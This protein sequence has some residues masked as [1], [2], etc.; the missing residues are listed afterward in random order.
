[1]NEGISTES[2][3]KSEPVALRP[4]H[5]LKSQASPRLYAHKRKLKKG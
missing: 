4:V 5:R 3:D 2:A 1:M